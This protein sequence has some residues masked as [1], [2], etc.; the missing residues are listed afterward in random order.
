MALALTEFEVKTAPVVD[1]DN[2]YLEEKRKVGKKMHA[3]EIILLAVGA[4][5]GALLR[6]KLVESP[7]LLG[8]LQ[9]NVLMVSCC[10]GV[11]LGRE[12]F[13]TCSSWL[14]WFLHDYVL[15]CFGNQQLT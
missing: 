7:V 12:V 6:Y 13:I 2:A 11:Q 5:I 1:A 14:L 8:G 15:L 3:I 10:I 4:V 9:V